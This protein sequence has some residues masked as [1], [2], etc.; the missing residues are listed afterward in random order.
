MIRN[1]VIHRESYDYDTLSSQFQFVHNNSTR[2]IF[3]QFSNYM[4]IDNPLSPVMRYQRNLRRAVDIKSVSYKTGNEVEV[5]FTSLVKNIY[6]E[7]LENMVWQ[8]TMSYE[9]D[10]SVKSTI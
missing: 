2:I 4:N 1:Y 7:I 5:I 10:R 3:L 8:A 6:N 9:I